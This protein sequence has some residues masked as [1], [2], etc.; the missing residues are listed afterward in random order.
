[1]QAN[2]VTV[3]NLLTSYID[4]WEV[5]EGRKPAQHHKFLLK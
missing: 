5:T 1:M 3:S 2:K 4:H